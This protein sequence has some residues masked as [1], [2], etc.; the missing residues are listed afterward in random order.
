MRSA[1]KL[2]IIFVNVPDMFFELTGSLQ[3][4]LI[5]EDISEW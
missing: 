1:W 4:Q 2:Q 3:S 5:F